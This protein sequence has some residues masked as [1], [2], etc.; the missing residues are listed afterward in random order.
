[1]FAGD[2]TYPL[3]YYR[4]NFLRD[5]GIE[6]RKKIPRG[7]MILGEKDAYISQTTCTE[8]KN[9]YKGFQTE[10]LKGGRHFIQQEN[11]EEVN[12]ILRKFLKK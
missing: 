1:M 6:R 5:S 9:K 12:E 4:S 7:L 3:N 11:Y 8:I 2:F 10:I